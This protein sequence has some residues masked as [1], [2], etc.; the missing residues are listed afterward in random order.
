[1]SHGDCLLTF[2]GSY[3]DDYEVGRLVAAGDF[4]YFFRSNAL[5]DATWQL[6]ALQ[7]STQASTV[8]NYCPVCMTTMVTWLRIVLQ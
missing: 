4:V 2:D 3:I 5:A 8:S 7:L 6:C 1:M